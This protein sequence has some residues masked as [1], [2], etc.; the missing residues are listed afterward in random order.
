MNASK[1]DEKLRKLQ[2]LADRGATEGERNAAREGIRRLRAKG[3]PAEPERPA[4]SRRETFTDAFGG[5]P[6]HVDIADFGWGGWV[7]RGEYVTVKPSNTDGT[8]YEPDPFSVP[9]SWDVANAWANGPRRTIVA[10][11]VH[12]HRGQWTDAHMCAATFTI[13]RG[14]ALRFL[15]VSSVVVTLPGRDGAMA[16]ECEVT[17]VVLPN[18]KGEEA[19]VRVRVVDF[20]KPATAA[21]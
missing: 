4:G 6:Y 1:Y 7:P 16:F 21:L 11:E 10:G 20:A 5:R 3:K 9:R 18:A 14:D 2:A 13:G 15:R 19:T 12:G 8:A 17:G